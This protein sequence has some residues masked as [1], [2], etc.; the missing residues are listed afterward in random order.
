MQ[1]FLLSKVSRFIAFK[2][3]SPKFDSRL[4]KSCQFAIDITMSMPKT[5]VD[6][7]YLFIFGKYEIRA[8]WQFV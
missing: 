1:L 7:N 8:P 5:A 3:F 6:E 4:R 2:F